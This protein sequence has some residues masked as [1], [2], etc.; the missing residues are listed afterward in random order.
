MHAMK[1]WQ[2]AAITFSIAWVVVL[3]VY[4]GTWAYHRFTCTPTVRTLPDGSIF[5]QACLHSPVPSQTIFEL[6]AYFAG[7]VAVITVLSWVFLG[8]PADIVS[9]Y[10]AR[11]RGNR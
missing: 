11:W 3:G 5:R 2:K 7:G 6:A 4:V 9:G 8:W 10:F 1:Y